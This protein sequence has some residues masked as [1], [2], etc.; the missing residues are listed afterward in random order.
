VIIESDMIITCCSL[1]KLLG[2]AHATF[3]DSHVNNH[4][5]SSCS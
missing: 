1:I 5:A 2:V 3:D 4:S